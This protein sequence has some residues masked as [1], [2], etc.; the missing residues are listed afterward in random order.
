[1]AVPPALAAKGVTLATYSMP[2]GVM[3]LAGAPSATWAQT[4]NPLLVED[5]A[6]EAFIAGVRALSAD[7]LD[8][9]TSFAP[10]A[11]IPPELVGASVS[12]KSS[13]NVTLE[14]TG[15]TPTGAELQVVAAVAGG[16]HPGTYSMKVEES[17]VGGQLTITNWTLVPA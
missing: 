14:V 7:R 4:T 12:Y 6:V 3:S 10:T 2:M 1:M 8:W 9:W 13:L 11:P 17:I 16:A 5:S 15:S